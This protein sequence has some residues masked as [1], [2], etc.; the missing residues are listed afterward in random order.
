MF[1]WR[2]A[3]LGSGVCRCGLSVI[4]RKV[5]C[6]DRC[7]QVE[8]DVQSVEALPSP[9]IDARLVLQIGQCALTRAIP[10]PQ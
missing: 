10:R 4:L 7:V 2:H 9:I 5:F 1:E 6:T 8:D 3:G